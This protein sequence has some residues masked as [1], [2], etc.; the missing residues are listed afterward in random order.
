MIKY[1]H[2]E[3]N[4]DCRNFQGRFTANYPKFLFKPFNST[5]NVIEFYTH[6]FK[7]MSPFFADAA[8]VVFSRDLGPVDGFQRGANHCLKSRTLS[9]IIT[10]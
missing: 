3:S 9:K 10:L 4:Q 6:L 8:A 5:K 1:R 2:F 7:D